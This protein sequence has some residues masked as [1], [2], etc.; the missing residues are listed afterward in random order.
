GMR[1]AVERIEQFGAGEHSSLEPVKERRLKSGDM[2]RDSGGRQPAFREH[3]P[4]RH[5][6]VER[7]WIESRAEKAPRILGIA[8]AAGR[9]TQILELGVP[10]GARRALA[11]TRCGVEKSTAPT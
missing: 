7:A 6:A 11:E 1:A 2:R 9:E 4:H 3:P 10:A 8:D 5:E